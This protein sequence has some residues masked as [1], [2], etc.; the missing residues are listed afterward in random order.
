M[1]FSDL[2]LA[3]LMGEEPSYVKKRSFLNNDSMGALS[4]SSLNSAANGMSEDC[5]DEIDVRLDEFEPRRRLGGVLSNAVCENAGT[6]WG[7]EIP[8]AE[9]GITGAAEIFEISG[10]DRYLRTSF[11]NNG[12]KLPAGSVRLDVF[13]DDALRDVDLLRKRFLLVEAVISGLTGRTFL[14]F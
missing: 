9:A 8:L 4:G 12:R 6:G 7:F 14:F 10:L 11:G 3:D 5:M 2:S 13:H 1:P